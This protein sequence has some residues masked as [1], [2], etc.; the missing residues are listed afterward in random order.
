M[1]RSRYIFIPVLLVIFSCS[2]HYRSDKMDLGFYQWNLWIDEEAGTDTALG[3]HD[4]SCGW[5]TM[6]LGVGKLVRI[7]TL[8]GDQFPEGTAGAAWYH[9]RFSLPDLWDKSDVSIQFDSVNGNTEVYLN[10]ELA[11]SQPKTDK[12][13]S[14][15]LSGKIYYTRDNHIA[16]RIISE[17]PRKTGI[18]GKVNLKSDYLAEPPQS[19]P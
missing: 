14:L 16:I 1:F 11:A 2:H 5:E 8:V 17:D 13:F 12:P 6:K 19:E 4:P 15:D 9:C 3:T 7:P 18:A 10:G